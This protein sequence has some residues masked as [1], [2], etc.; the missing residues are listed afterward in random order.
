METVGSCACCSSC[1]IRWRIAGAV[2]SSG[3]SLR[4]RLYAAIAVVVSAACSAVWASANWMLGSFGLSFA[5]SWYAATA[6]LY[7][8]VIFE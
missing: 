2:G 4:K 1:L 7:A 6:W 3:A 5:T 8:A